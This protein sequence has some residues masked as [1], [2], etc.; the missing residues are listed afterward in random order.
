MSAVAA[1]GGA[2]AGTAEE[3]ARVSA[4]EAGCG[5]PDGRGEVSALSLLQARPLAARLDVWPFV[6][7]YVGWL[8]LWHRQG[9]GDTFELGMLASGG[10][11]W[12]HA[13][14]HLSTMWSV[15]A[16]RKGR[17]TGRHCPIPLPPSIPSFYVLPP[18]FPPLS[19]RT[20]PPPGLSMRRRC[21][22]FPH[23]LCLCVLH[24]RPVSPPWPRSTTRHL[25]PDAI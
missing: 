3:A 11:L 20:P 25:C 10:L 16:Q 18:G 24:P 5:T 14:V 15:A 13:I 21:P 12:L 4:T 17:A 2:R 8:A 9:M 19:H 7:L 6:L 1:E 23:S 22:R